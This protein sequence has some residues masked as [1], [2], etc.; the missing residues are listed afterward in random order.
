MPVKVG[1]CCDRNPMEP[2]HCA[3]HPP[4]VP[5]PGCNKIHTWKHHFCRHEIMSVHQ[6]LAFYTKLRKELDAEAK[7][8]QTGTQET[9]R[10]CD[11]VM[12]DIP[13]KFDREPLIVSFE[14]TKRRVVGG[15]GRIRPANAPKLEVIIRDDAA[16][17]LA[18]Y[19]K[20][21]VGRP[22]AAPS[23]K[24]ADKLAKGKSVVVVVNNSAANDTNKNSGSGQKSSA[25]RHPA[26]GYKHKRGQA[27]RERRDAVQRGKL[28]AKIAAKVAAAAL[29]APSTSTAS[30]RY[31]PLAEDKTGRDRQKDVPSPPVLSVPDVSM[32]EGSPTPNPVA[33]QQ[34]PPPLVQEDDLEVI[35]MDIE[36]EDRTPVVQVFTE[37]EIR[38]LFES[39][40]EA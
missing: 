10:V 15:Y 39:D 31:A 29:N 22:A 36:Q 35:P 23:K 5:H 2:H 17:A 7:F 40:E 4:G 24:E 32:G 26:A 33:C 11:Q 30:N 12:A 20:M 28:A 37:E 8:G 25:G 27:A 14:E 16:K 19:K 21:A 38:D 3:G 6:T 1:L 34:A 9:A 13:K 18:D